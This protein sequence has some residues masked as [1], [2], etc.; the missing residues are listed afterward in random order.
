MSHIRLRERNPVQISV[1]RALDVHE[2]RK[3]ISR[4]KPGPANGPR[5]R[6][7]ARIRLRRNPSGRKRGQS[8]PRGRQESPDFGLSRTRS[9]FQRERIEIFPRAT[10]RVHKSPQKQSAAHRRSGESPRGATPFQ[11]GTDA[12]A[13][14]QCRP[15]EIPCSAKPAPAAIAHRERPP[16]TVREGAMGAGS[17]NIG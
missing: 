6:H 7:H 10:R 4:Y 1:R 15:G 8:L 16:L 2:M 9:H 11:P 3:L 5:A 17:G 13:I 14:I 12:M